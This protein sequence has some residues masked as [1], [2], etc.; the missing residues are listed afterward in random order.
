MVN[1]LLG[2][3]DIFGGGG[4]SGAQADFGALDRQL[5]A[6]SGHL[7]ALGSISRVSVTSARRGRWSTS[8]TASM[9]T[10]SIWAMTSKLSKQAATFGGDI[11][12]DIFGGGG[13]SGDQL[14]SLFDALSPFSHEF[15][16]IG[17]DFAKL[18]DIY[19]GGGGSG[20]NANDGGITGRGTC[21]GAAAAAAS[22]RCTKISWR[23]TVRCRGSPV[24][25]RAC[26]FR[27][28]HTTAA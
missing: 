12:A 8:K 23:L 10:C 25:S 14:R 27:R 9:P 5:F 16:G 1:Q 7:E 19:G 28:S 24:R 11:K 20:T 18:A 4:G 22:S 15:A 2:G 21:S 6:T 26:W 3:S 13:G 17:A